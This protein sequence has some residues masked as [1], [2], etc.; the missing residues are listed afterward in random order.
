M[1]I[2]LLW[3]YIRERCTKKTNLNAKTDAILHRFRNNTNDVSM[4]SL[5]FKN[6]NIHSSMFT[7][8]ISL[9][10]FSNL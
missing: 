3:C 9:S 7:F 4:L 10:E 6:G 8:I 5:H 1:L 2:L